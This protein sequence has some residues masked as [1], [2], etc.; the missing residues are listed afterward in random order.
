MLSGP[1]FWTRLVGPFRKPV[2]PA[3][4]NVPN[5]FT[6]VKK[7]MDLGTIQTKL[8]AREYNTAAEFEAD[9]RQIFSNCYEYWTQDDAVFKMCEMFEKHFNEKWSDQNKWVVPK[10]KAEVID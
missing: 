10:I 5:Y 4:D 2:D 7:P 8:F 1:G 9:V 6:V 3:A